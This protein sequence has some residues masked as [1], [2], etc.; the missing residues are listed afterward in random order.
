MSARGEH[1][2]TGLSE[3]V[4]RRFAD[5]LTQQYDGLAERDPI[6]AELR[7][8]FDL[9]VVAALLRT[10]GLA[11]SAG[12]ERLP[13]TADLGY[14]PPRV[15]PKATVP[16]VVNHKVFGGRDIVVQVAGGVQAPVLDLL[17][18]TTM[19][20]A[21]ST[22]VSPVATHAAGESPRTGWTWSR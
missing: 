9:A 7:N 22:L 15:P 11:R 2:P 6:F 19:W 3:P 18:P 4:N 14:T 5:N 10:Q 17:Q 8:I 20:R 1:L 13:F 16:S 12:W 21:D